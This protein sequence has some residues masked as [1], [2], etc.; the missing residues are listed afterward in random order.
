MYAYF[1]INEAI[2][3]KYFDNNKNNL[4]ICDDGRYLTPRQI[5]GWIRG[6]LRAIPE[7]IIKINPMSN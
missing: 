6:I 3:Q 2:T 7:P 1:I 5:N 4:P